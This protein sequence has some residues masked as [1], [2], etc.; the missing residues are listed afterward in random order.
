MNRQ[1]VMTAVFAAGL[2][3]LVFYWTNAAFKSGIKGAQSRLKTVGVKIDKASAL[4]AQ[5]RVS[6][7]HSA[8]MTGGLLSFLQTAAE[9]D[10]LGDKI[11]GIKPKTVPGASEAATIRLENL[12]YDQAVS[13]LNSVERYSNISSSNVKISKRFDNEKML[14]LVMDTVKR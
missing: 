5:A 11:A 13:F 10:G 14:N 2:I 4:A 9:K 3:F 6:G 8:M 7:R 12:T 1:Q